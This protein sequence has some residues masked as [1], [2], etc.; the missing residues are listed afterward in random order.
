MNKRNET[1]KI[2]GAFLVLKNALVATQK[3]VGPFMFTAIN[4]GISN[5]NCSCR[6]FGRIQVGN[7]DLVRVVVHFDGNNCVLVDRLQERCVRNG[8]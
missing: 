7:D 3:V 2:A 4:D 8:E 6:I 1:L 5:G